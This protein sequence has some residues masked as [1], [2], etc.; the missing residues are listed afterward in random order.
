MSKHHCIFTENFV[1]FISNAGQTG[2]VPDSNLTIPRRHSPGD[3]INV[4]FIL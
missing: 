4:T 2:N 1:I 3:G